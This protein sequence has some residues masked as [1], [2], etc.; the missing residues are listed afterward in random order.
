MYQ[1]HTDSALY[2]CFKT[3]GKIN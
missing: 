3:F 2:Q 1:L